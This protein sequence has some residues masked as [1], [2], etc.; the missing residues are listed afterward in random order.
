[1][2]AKG[3]IV[4]YV[5]K[6]NSDP[7]LVTDNHISDIIHLIDT[8][9]RGFDELSDAIR[10]LSECVSPITC[11]EELVPELKNVKHFNYILP[12]RNIKPKHQLHSTLDSYT[13]DD[14]DW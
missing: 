12:D 1:M 4:N 9:E 13:E 7:R 6:Y 3:R 2:E 11:V 10:F 5:V 14:S 8:D